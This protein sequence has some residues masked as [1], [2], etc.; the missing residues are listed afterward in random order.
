MFA[1]RGGGRGKGFNQ[2]HVYYQEAEPEHVDQ[3]DEAFYYEGSYPESD[4]AYY[5]E[6]DQYQAAWRDSWDEYGEEEQW[7]EDP[8]EDETVLRL[9]EEVV[10]IQKKKKSELD[11]MLAEADRNL[12]EARK[13]VA[14]AAKDRG[15]AGTVQHKQPRATSSYKE[16]PKRQSVPG[17]KV[18]ARANIYGPPMDQYWMNKG[19]GKQTGK[20]GFQKGKQEQAWWIKRPLQLLHLQHLWHWGWRLLV[21]SSSKRTIQFDFWEKDERDRICGGHRSRRNS[22]RQEGSQQSSS[23]G[24]TG[25]EAGRLPKRS[26]MVSLWQRAG[27]SAVCEVTLRDLT[28]SYRIACLA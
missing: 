2:R 5:E 6:Y 1:D 21:Q 4:Y 19:G 26:T 8:M 18:H 20:Y 14:A 12:A 23:C 17:A 25:C 28:I 13:A 27:G 7:P 10:E 22:W 3:Y 11:A 9:Q 15:W 16:R 24:S